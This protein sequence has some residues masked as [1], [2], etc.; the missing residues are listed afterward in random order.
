MKK[1]FFT[2]VLY[3]YS[4]PTAFAAPSPAGC[5]G[6][7]LTPAGTKVCVGTGV[8]STVPSIL[9][10]FISIQIRGAILLT[11][12]LFLLGAIIMVG[13][14]GE[15]A[16]LSAGKKIMKA[17]IIGLVIILSSWLILETVISFIAS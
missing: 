7:G 10:G 15:E 17:A 14:G 4:F 1:I 13:S 2:V 3:L 6:D 11:L 5:I 9:Q 8:H 16:Y 12:G